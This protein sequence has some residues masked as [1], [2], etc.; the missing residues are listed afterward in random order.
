MFLT[1]YYHGDQIGSS[2]LMTDGTGHPIW[3]GTFLPYG[4]EYQPQITVNNYKFS[5][6]E[7]DAESGLD[8]FGARYY[9][10]SM[11]RWL[12]PDWGEKPMAIPYAQYDDPQS[13]NL[14]GYVRNNP[15][16]RIDA[17]GHEI[18]NANNNDRGNTKWV[19]CDSQQCRDTDARFAD[20]FFTSFAMVTGRIGTLYFGAQAIHDW[21][22]GNKKT[23]ALGMLAVIP[24]ERILGQAAKI[25][26]AAKSLS[27]FE[28]AAEF[29]IKS[30]KEM[31]IAIKGTGLEAH[32]LIPQRFADTLG[33]KAADMA[34]IALTNTEHQVFT[35][36]WRALIPY[37]EGTAQATKQNVM[38]AARQV[39]KDYPEVLQSLGLKGK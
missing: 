6:K 21:N 4:E 13:L 29:G 8:Y 25:G 3:Q 7:R 37:G 5:G 10:S 9:G 20:F 26:M 27:R 12:S 33:V 16:T 22:S 28:K 1:S 31:T 15:I 38:D 35:N 14:Y 11:G 2:R 18:L 32:H 19:P 36:A 17:D 24:G 34:S 30:Y 39:Y 23:A